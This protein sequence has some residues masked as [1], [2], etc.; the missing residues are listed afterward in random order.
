MTDLGELKTL[1]QFV[2]Y[3]TSHFLKIGCYV[4]L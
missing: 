3:E 1:K 4:L 2:A